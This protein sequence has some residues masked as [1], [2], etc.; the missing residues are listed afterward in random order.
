MFNKRSAFSAAFDAW[1]IEVVAAY[2]PEQTVQRDEQLFEFLSLGGFAAGLNWA[3]VFNKRSAFSAAF[4]A[5][6]IEVVAAYRPEQTVQRDEQLFE[7]LSLGGF[8]AGL[9]WAVVFNTRSAFSAAFDAWQNHRV[10]A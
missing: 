2:R 1:Q 5:W 6:Q 9:N 4:D 8:A 7:F 3:V 10:A